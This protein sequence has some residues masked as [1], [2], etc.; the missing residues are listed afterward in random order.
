M[1]KANNA[2]IN[3]LNSLL[4]GENMA[5]DSIEKVI[6]H[7][8]DGNIK[9]ELQKIQQ[10]HK[11]HTALLADR[12]QDLG[13]APAKGVGLGGKAAEM[14][15]SVKDIGKTGTASH[16]KEILDG[17]NKGIQMSTELVKG[18][19]DSDSAKLVNTILDEDRNNVNML[20]EVLNSIDRQ[21]STT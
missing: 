3:E 9:N 17:E 5:V 8:D 15:S 12:I 14:M 11:Q 18:D 6:A 2:S 10:N 13:G 1:D 16:I 19:L 7:V 20:Q 4:K 21:N